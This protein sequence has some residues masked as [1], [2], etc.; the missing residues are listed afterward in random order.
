MNENCRGCIALIVLLGLLY[1]FVPGHI[2]SGHQTL[3][4]EHHGPR[5]QQ[6]GVCPG[7]IRGVHDKVMSR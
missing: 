1:R 4:A 5:C 6:A 7:R 3:D 2:I